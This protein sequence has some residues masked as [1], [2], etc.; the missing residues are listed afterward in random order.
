MGHKVNPISFRIPYIKTWKSTWYEDTK[1]YKDSLGL[2]IK[3]R[4]I[5]SKELTGVPL[6]DIL[7]ARNTSLIEVVVYT[8][9]AVLILGKNGENKERLQI[10][11]T[12]KL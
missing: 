11:L 8:A 7:V 6:G 4:T 1:T 10:L 9:K 12:N 5:L 3:A 2:D